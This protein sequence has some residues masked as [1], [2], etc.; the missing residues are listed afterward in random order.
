MRLTT[1]GRYAVTAMLDLALHHENG[2]VCLADI[3]ERQGISQSYLEQL[4]ARLRRNGLVD[5][6]RGPGGGYKLG[7]PGSAISVADVIDAVDENVDA[8]RCGGQRNCQ[9]DR[10]CLTHDLWAQLSCQI[11]NFLVDVSL[12]NLIHEKGVQTLHRLQDDTSFS[13]KATL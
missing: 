11:R 12:D 1:R 7:R 6:L 5:G 2:P 4:F 8:T 3:A 13:S 9:G 10:P